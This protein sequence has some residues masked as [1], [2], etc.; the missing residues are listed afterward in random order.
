METKRMNNYIAFRKELHQHPE[1]STQEFETQTRILSFLAGLGVSNAHPIGGTGVIVKFIGSHP[2]KT[3]LLRCDTDALPIQEINEFE[4]KSRNAGVSHKCGHDGHSTIMAAVASHLVANPISAGKVVLLFQPAEENGHGAKA[5]LAD[6]LF[7]FEPDLVFALHNV[8][9]FPLDQVVVKEGAFTPAVKSIIVKLDGKT[10]HA[11]EPELGLNPALAIAELIQFFAE[12]SQPDLTRDDF[13][14]TTPVYVHMGEK[15]YGVSAGHG[16]V[17][18][19]IRTWDSKAM[20]QI[21]KASVDASN[22]I[23]AKHGL[24]ATISWTEEF[25]SNQNDP[26]AVDIIRKSASDNDLE[27][28]EKE[29]PFKWGEDFGLFTERYKGAMFG[30]GAGATHPAL[31]NPDYDF[32]D[33]LILSG[34]QMFIR[35]IENALHV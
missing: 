8:P 28:L 1:I 22:E 35:I 21:A 5:V 30:L 17:H 9:S 12:V 19:T 26:R 18:Y 13:A 7:D 10:S 32:P 15:S 27:I 31:H 14:L 25:F 34:S 33:D 6:K 16:E 4:H 2:G 20:D 3:L 24:T 11:A 23:A 29:A